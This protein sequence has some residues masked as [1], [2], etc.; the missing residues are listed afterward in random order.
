[1]N[2]QHEIAPVIEIKTS[3]FVFL[4]RVALLEFCFALVPTL[5]ATLLGLRRSY[6]TLA[7]SRTVPYTLFTVMV[8]TALQ[9]IIIAVTFMRWY[10]TTY[11]IDYT[12]IVCRRG[13][14][15]EEQEI[16]LTQ[17]IT[18]IEVKQGRLGALLGYGTLEI[19][20]SD[21]K[22]KG[23]VRHIPRPGHY[24]KVIWQMVGPG[25]TEAGNWD[26]ESIIE[27]IAE[28]EGQHLEFK[29]SFVWDYRRESAN[30][31]LKHA[32][33]KNV[34]AFMNATGGV[35]LVG[36][37]D[38]GE[39]LGLEPDLRT[40][41][42]PNL[43]AFENV[44]NGAFNQMIGAEYRQYVDVVFQ[45]I[46]GVTISVLAVQPSSQPVYV[47]HKGSEEFY[48]RTGNCSQPL[49]ISQAAKYI[50]SHFTS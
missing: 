48:I 12:H 29:S 39:L 7:L 45:T 30:K 2:D 49:S 41:R 44:F 15:F 40:L 38:S 31:E 25:Q 4:K 20:T 13:S 16:A 3:P 11:R 42:A 18:A 23:Y 24:A 28:G 37:G 17:A 22:A 10:L 14:L 32:V 5:L 26:Q 50:Q 47:T 46:K 36:V 9:I 34:A 6:E 43:D 21:P 33:I 8:M 27:M 19:A 1:M 35:L